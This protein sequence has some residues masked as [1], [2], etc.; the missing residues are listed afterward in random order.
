MTNEPINKSGK[1]YWH[2]VAFT[3]SNYRDYAIIAPS[4]EHAQA[5]AA[6]LTGVRIKRSTV[7]PVTVTP[8]KTVKCA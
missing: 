5:L 2:A 6:R 7:Q 1:L 3:D 8:R 4:P